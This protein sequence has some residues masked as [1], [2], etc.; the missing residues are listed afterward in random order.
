MPTRIYALAKDLKLDSKDLVD[1]CTKAGIP[2]KGSALASLE[3]DEVVKLKAYLEGPLRSGPL[4]PPPHRSQC[5][6][7]SFRPCRGH[8]TDSAAAGSHHRAALGPVRCLRETPEFDDSS[9]AVAVEEPP[10][11]VAEAKPEA[12]AARRQAARCQSPRCAAASRSRSRAPVHRRQPSKSQRP[13][14]RLRQNLRHLSAGGSSA[15]A[16]RATDRQCPAADLQ[17]SR[18]DYSFHRAPRSAARRPFGQSPRL[19]SRARP[20]R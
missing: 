6:G 7:G 15:A 18:A 1:I 10:V 3:D 13:S 17:H 9:T 19:H 11:I 14:A 12:P 20:A 16:R 4:P 5:E 2:G 8:D